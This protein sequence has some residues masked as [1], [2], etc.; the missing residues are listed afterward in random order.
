MTAFTRSLFKLSVFV[1]IW[2]SLAYVTVKKQTMNPHL[3][4][5]IQMVPLIYI[6]VFGTYSLISIL[7]KV[8]T[9]RNHPSEYE[10]LK[11]NIDEARV[12]Y[13]QYPEIPLDEASS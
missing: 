1:S 6:A 7:Y 5:F 13:K 12:Y 10:R 3:V 8:I 9:L 11:R 4:L 2:M